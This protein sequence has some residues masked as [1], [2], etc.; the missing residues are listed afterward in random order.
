LRGGFAFT[1]T[2][3][4]NLL[5]FRFQTADVVD[6]AGLTL[7]SFPQRFHVTLSTD[8]D[9]IG[10]IFLDSRQRTHCTHPGFFHGISVTFAASVS[11]LRFYCRNNQFFTRLASPLGSF[12]FGL[13]EFL[14]ARITSLSP[15]RV[16]LPK[17]FKTSNASDHASF[18]NYILQ[19]R[20]F[21]A[22][23]T[24]RPSFTKFLK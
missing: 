11:P 4:T 9:I 3:T 5:P 8:F 22:N 20:D 7:F 24:G 19:C 2:S 12:F 6:V 23:G 21:Y 18:T 13:F 10:P 16:I 1:V 15:V 14:V 17:C